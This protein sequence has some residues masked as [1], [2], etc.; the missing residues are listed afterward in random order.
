MKAHLAR[1]DEV[2]SI[3]NAVLE[4]NPDAITVARELDEER[5]T[6]GRRGEYVPYLRLFGHL[7]FCPLGLDL[8]WRLV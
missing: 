7:V 8:T 5:K 4:V 3:F 1:I 6:D 2:N